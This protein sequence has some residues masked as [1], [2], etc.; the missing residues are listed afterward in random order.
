MGVVD[1]VVGVVDLGIGKVRIVGMMDGNKCGC[2]WRSHTLVLTKKY[3]C[4]F[5]VVCYLYICQ[6]G[7]INTSK[8][9]IR[10]SCMCIIQYPQKKN[11]K[12]TPKKN[13]PSLPFRHLY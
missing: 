3:F 2:E 8:F 7:V 1:V 13:Q 6:D 9:A 11:T 4:L 10:V 12:K 5:L